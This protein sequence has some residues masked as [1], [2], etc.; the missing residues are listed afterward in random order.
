MN[1]LLVFSPLK[2]TNQTDNHGSVAPITD[3]ELSIKKKK[4]KSTFFNDEKKVQALSIVL[5][6]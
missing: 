6:I 2:Y 3:A 4:K 5:S 1:G